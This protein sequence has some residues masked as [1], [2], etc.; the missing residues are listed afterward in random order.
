MAANFYEQITV[1]S[2]SIPLTAIPDDA[3]SATIQTNGAA[4]RF[5]IDGTAATTSTG[6]VLANGRDA[7]IIGREALAGLRMIRDDGTDATLE[8]QYTPLLLRV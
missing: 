6:T 4:I 2:S 3:R 7:N 5:K 8:V 1:S